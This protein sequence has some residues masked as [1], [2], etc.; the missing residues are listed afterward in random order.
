M[1]MG[2]GKAATSLVL[3]STD[4]ALCQH[5]RGR[6]R[7]TKISTIVDAMLSNLFHHSSIESRNSILNSPGSTPKTCMV[8]HAPLYPRTSSL[9]CPQ[10]VATLWLRSLLGP[11]LPAPGRHSHHRR[12]YRLHLSLLARPHRG[13][14][15]PFH[16]RRHPHYS[17][18]PNWRQPGACRTPMRPACRQPPAILGTR[19]LQPMDLRNAR[20]VPS[21]TQA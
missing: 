6:L 10:Y 1:T 20:P 8:V 4:A 3:L 19:L 9:D 13:P 21:S 11:R 15:T 14:P 16:N 5:L 18:S 2:R 17:R 12:G 7:N